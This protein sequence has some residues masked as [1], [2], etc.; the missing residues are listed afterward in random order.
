MNGT[1]GNNR[2][3]KNTCLFEFGQ[4]VPN[5]ALRFARPPD[6]DL[7]NDGDSLIDE[8]VTPNGPIR[9]FDIATFHDSVSIF[10]AVMDLRYVTLEDVVGRS[11]AAR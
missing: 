8:Y 2:V 4:H 10:P 1:A 5:G 9:N 3:G 7:D 11:V 6:D